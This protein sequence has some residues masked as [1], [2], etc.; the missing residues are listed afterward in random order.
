MSSLCVCACVCVCLCVRVCDAVFPRGKVFEC[1]QISFLAQDP[2]W[3]PSL[4]VYSTFGKSVFC[5]LCVWKA[6]FD[7]Q[8]NLNAIMNG[9]SAFD[10]NL[11]DPFLE[12][13]CVCGSSVY[14][15]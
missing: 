6:R 4:W 15:I 11:S 12:C 2:S 7:I 1:S 3:C 9:W 14:V 8:E 5:L 10:F 13:V